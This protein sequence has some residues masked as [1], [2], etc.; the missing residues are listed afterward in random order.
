MTPTD[1]IELAHSISRRRVLCIS[2]AAFGFLG[3][4]LIVHPVFR[5][6][7]YAA[8]GWRAYAWAFNAFLLLLLI[9]PIGG[10]KWGPRVRALV[11]DEISRANAHT[12][13]R[14]GFWLAMVI[15]LG[16]YVVGP[17]R[18]L[19][20]REGAYLIVTPTTIVVLLAFAWLE[21][22]ALRDG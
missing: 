15:A 7:G 5:T 1:T 13:A 21:S 3:V 8:S 20:A 22:R 6:D 14:W 11:N 9:L 12:A 10:A 2:L 18:A 17:A 16:I 19:T 4:Q